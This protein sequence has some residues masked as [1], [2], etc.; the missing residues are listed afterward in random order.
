MS[1][2][3]RDI[4]AYRPS[5]LGACFGNS[6][7]PVTVLRLQALALLRTTSTEHLA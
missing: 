4:Y 2:P 7:S 1:I 5:V 3:M 6:G